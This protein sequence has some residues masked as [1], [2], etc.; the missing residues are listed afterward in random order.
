MTDHVVRIK[1]LKLEF[2]TDEGVLKALGGVDLDIPR[3][4]ILGLVGETGCGKSVLGSAILGLT[5]KPAGKITEG[6]IIFEG[7]DISMMSEKEL[8]GIRGKKI[9]MI[10]QDPFNS[11]NP[12]YT[13]GDQITEAI[14]LHQDVKGN[15]TAKQKAIDI[16][17]AVGIPF[18]IEFMN[19][20]P[21]EFSG[22]MLQRVMIAIAL[23]CHPQV[24]IADEPTTALDVTIQ[25]QILKLLND[26]NKN[27]GTAIL[28]ISHDLGVIFQMCHS[29]AVMYSGYIVELAAAENFIK[30]YKHPYSKGLIGSIPKIGQRAEYL[31]I[32]PGNLPDPI[33]PPPGCRFAPRC[34]FTMEQC[35]IKRPRLKETTAGH[36]VACFLIEE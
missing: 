9:S 32:I 30:N 28:L 4:E 5:P 1:N 21:H 2:H 26:L 7:R 31:D 25:A 15:M 22:G 23:S 18:P 12:A 19:S 34:K 3:G 36:K 24:L 16:M 10:F 11:L 20:Y 14:L 8:R 29:I 27:T 6:Q 35:Q 33:H 17:G 13:I